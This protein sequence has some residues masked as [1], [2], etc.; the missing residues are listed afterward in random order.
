MV[1]NFRPIVAHNVLILSQ[2]E[3]ARQTA[4]KKATAAAAKAARDQAA[5]DARAH[6]E[7]R[8]TQEA[9]RARAE[10]AEQERIRAEEVGC[11]GI[12]RKTRAF[13]P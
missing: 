2:A 10:A 13:E 5:K 6:E 3:K 12:V 9:V 1:A 7:V 11:A 4:Q 8:R